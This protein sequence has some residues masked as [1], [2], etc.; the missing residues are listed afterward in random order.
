MITVITIGSQAI[1]LVAMPTTPGPKSLQM[2]VSDAVGSVT[3]PFTGQVQ[4]F[5]WPGADMWKGTVTMP[6]MEQADADNWISFLMELRG[7][8]NAFQIGDPLKQTPR[9]IP[10]GTPVVDNSVAANAAASQSLG[11]S[12]WTASTTNL[13]MVGDYIQVGYRLHRV[14]DAVDSDADG[15]AVIN[16]WPSL[17]E[18]PTNGETLITSNTQGLFRLASNS[19][20]WSADETLTTSLSFAIQECR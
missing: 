20:T 2:T 13:L 9:G 6:P 10:S 8:A 7:M 17:R 4:T 5:Q 12:G 14:L 1:N 19:R 11:T 16:I 15:N 3:S 18:V